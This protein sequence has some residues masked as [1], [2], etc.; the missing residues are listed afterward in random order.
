MDSCR[1]HGDEPLGTVKYVETLEKLSDWQ[2]LKKDSALWSY[3]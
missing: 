3:K 1:E 2:L